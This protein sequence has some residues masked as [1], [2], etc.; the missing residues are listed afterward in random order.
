MSIW[1]YIIYVFL[2]ALFVLILVAA[3]MDWY[4]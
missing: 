2:G 1:E 4:E 3:I